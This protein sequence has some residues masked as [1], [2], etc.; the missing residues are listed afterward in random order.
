M[1]ATKL[2]INFINTSTLFNFV[3]TRL[4]AR[5]IKTHDYT[6]QVSGQDYVFE[7]IDDSTKGYMTAQG[8][9]ITVGD[10]ITLQDGAEVYHYQVEQIEYY[11]NPSDMWTGVLKRA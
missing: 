1:L 2:G 4:R 5:R 11:S 6:G 3:V 8:K 10:F 7:T 9:G